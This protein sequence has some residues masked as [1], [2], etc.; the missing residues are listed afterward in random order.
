ML[1]RRNQIIIWVSLG[2]AI[3]LVLLVMLYM[4]SNNYECQGPILFKYVLCWF[5]DDST[6]ITQHIFVKLEFYC[7]LS[8]VCL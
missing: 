2:F 6:V 3:L 5:V 1:F 8:C 4:K 7:K